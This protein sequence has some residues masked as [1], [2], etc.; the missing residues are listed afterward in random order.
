[1]RWR[2][3]RRRI[4]SSFDHRHIKRRASS[5]ARQSLLAALAPLAAWATVV[6]LAVTQCSTNRTSNRQLREQQEETRTQQ[7][8]T[9]QGQITDRFSKA[10]D[11]LGQ[12]GGDKVDIRLGGVYAL[13][14]IMKDSR[15]DEPAII[16]VL[17]AFISGHD[18]ATTGPSADIRAALIVLGSRPDPDI[19]ANAHIELTGNLTRAPLDFAYLNGAY[20]TGANLTAGHL[21]SA[22]LYDAELHHIYLIGADLTDADFRKA[23]LTGAILT[24][25]D[26]TGADLRVADLT[27]ADLTGATLTGADL[28]GANLTSTTVTTKDLIGALINFSTTLPPGIIVPTPSPSPALV[29][30]HM[31]FGARPNV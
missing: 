1:M 27:G 5:G 22:H 16:D 6:V 17:C 4:A 8:L 18:L 24:G 30:P 15:D 11:Q 14:R 3:S 23:D 9:A 29:L 7:S 13:A 10:I 21:H 20:M 2:V 19:P 25:A 12:E 26:L 31:W 28:R